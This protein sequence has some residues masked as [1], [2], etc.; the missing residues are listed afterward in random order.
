MRPFFYFF[1][2]IF[3]VLFFL[4]APLSAWAELRLFMAEQAG[5]VWCE[6][7][8]EEIGPIYPHSAE[9][10]AAPLV[11]FDLFQPPSQVVFSGPLRYSPSFV[12]VRDGAELGRIEGYPGADFFW[13]MLADLFKKAGVVPQAGE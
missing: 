7:W 9:G 10:R 8:H 5:C 3:F 11:R 6:R 1:F 2:C 13:A 12:L 4:L